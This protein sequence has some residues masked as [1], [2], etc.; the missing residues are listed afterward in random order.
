MN[1]Y[2]FDE[3]NGLQSSDFLSASCASLEGFCHIEDEVSYM[4]GKTAA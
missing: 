4:T 2:T 3:S 1:K